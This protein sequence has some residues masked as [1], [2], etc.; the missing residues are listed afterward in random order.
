MKQYTHLIEMEGVELSFS[1]DALARIAAQ[2]LERRTGARGLRSIL[3]QTMLNVMFDIPS[4]TNIKEVIVTPECIENG[5]D[6]IVVYRSEKMA[7]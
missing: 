4:S 5:Q 1:E 3:E 7:G 6:P 2:A